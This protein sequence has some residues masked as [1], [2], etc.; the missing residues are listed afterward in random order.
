MNAPAAGAGSSL[1]PAAAVLVV[2]ASPAHPGWWA[3]YPQFIAAG[4]VTSGGWTGE[5]GGDLPGLT[6]HLQGSTIGVVAGSLPALAG[7]LVV[8]PIDY[9]VL[10]GELP[11]LTG[12]LVADSSTV[13]TA[14]PGTT[15]AAPTMVAALSS[16]NRVAPST[17]LLVINDGGGSVTLTIATPYT[18]EGLALGDATVTI[19]NGSW[20]SNA[21]LVDVP[22][23][24]YAQPGDGLCHLTWSSPVGVTFAVLGRHAI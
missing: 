4:V 16:G 9:G 23:G 18:A 19:P 7:Q 5:V 15:G 24:L 3:Q 11:A 13:A 10:A 14:R 12:A 8:Q 21:R 22:Y 2:S 6:G 1:A 20:P 17:R